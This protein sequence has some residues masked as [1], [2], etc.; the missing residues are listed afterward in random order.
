MG[1][2]THEQ[3]GY[4]GDDIR[5]GVHHRASLGVHVDVPEHGAVHQR[6]QEEVD[7]AHQHQR[8]AHLHQGLVVL[9][10]GA[11]Q[12]WSTHTR[13]ARCNY[14]HR[15]ATVQIGHPHLWAAH[16]FKHTMACMR[17]H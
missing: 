5:D 3:A 6:P 8:Q 9:E 12:S 15:G 4:D 2:R 11:A 7:V 17:S 16:T 14:G 13:T 10:A 1:G